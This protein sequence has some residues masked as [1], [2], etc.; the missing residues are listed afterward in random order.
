MKFPA[1]WSRGTVEDQDRS[2]QPVRFSCWRWSDVS[3]QDAQQSA[4]AAARR[5][6]QKLIAGEPLDRYG[7]G[8]RPMREEVKQQ[9][10]GDDGEPLAAITQNAYG[11]LV[12]NTARVLFADVDFPPVPPGQQIGHFFKKWFDKQSRPPAEVAREQA[13]E[14]IVNFVR[15]NPA[16]SA[17]LYRTHSGYRLLATHAMFDPA[18]DATRAAFDALGVDPLYRRLCREQA[19][20]RARLTPK[21]WRCGHAANV[22][23]WPR[24]SEESQNR[25]AIWH[26]QYLERQA[27]YATCQFVDALGPG[28]V[29]PEAAR[30]VEL[31][32]E[33]TRCEESLEL[34]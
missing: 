16:W 3:E 27:A 24:P 7:Y 21:P 29:H 12:L 19:C 14:R 30:I 8:T 34:A 11:S 33:L 1:F 6:V 28:Q 32:D 13:H 18:D 31:H 10:A 25:F 22:I 5:I 4:L 15:D 17:R 9:F 26:E 20:F 2:G 23:P